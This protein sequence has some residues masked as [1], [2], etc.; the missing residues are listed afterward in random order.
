MLCRQRPQ[1]L[2]QPLLATDAAK[3]CRVKRIARKTVQVPPRTYTRWIV[4][5]EPR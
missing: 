4:T 5:D 1:V 3:R 2:F